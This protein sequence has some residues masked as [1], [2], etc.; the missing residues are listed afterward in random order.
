ME[1]YALKVMHM[2][3]KL[4]SIANFTEVNEKSKSCQDDKQQHFNQFVMSS[5]FEKNLEYSSLVDYD[6]FPKEYIQK[7]ALVKEISD[8]KVRFEKV[9]IALRGKDAMIS[10]LQDKL[11]QNTEIIENLQ[12][13]KTNQT[14]ES[15]SVDKINF[16]YYVKSI[17]VENESLKTIV[18][19]LQDV[20][21]KE[22]KTSSELQSDYK[23]AVEKVNEYKKECMQNEEKMK[24][25]KSNEQLSNKENEHLKA[26][27]LELQSQISI[28][29]LLLNNNDNTMTNLSVDLSNLKNELKAERK[30]S[31]LIK[32]ALSQSE[33]VAKI[34]LD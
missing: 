14:S 19:K 32:N 18:A 20:H 1:E 5:D 13:E 23:F 8:R 27:V 4:K 2:V 25:L 33:R 12:R 9:L 17:S 31:M 15:K 16:D 26:V 3:N 7:H 34:A 28:K 10:N 21:E 30:N 29:Q 24:K 6:R 22:K 11:R